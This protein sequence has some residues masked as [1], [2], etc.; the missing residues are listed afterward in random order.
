MTT[1]S[2]AWASQHAAHV[3]T[4]GVPTVAMVALALGAE[5]RSVVRRRARRTVVVSRRLTLL[6]AVCSLGA[7]AAHV[8]VAPE[9][10]HEAVLYGAFF[11]VAASAQLAWA[12]L[13]W[14]RPRRATLVAGLVGNASIVGLWVFTRTAE[15]PFGPGAGRPEGIGALDIVATSCEVVLVVV[16][17]AILASRRAPATVRP[18]GQ[19]VRP[20]ALGASYRSS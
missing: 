9:H 14:L 1:S 18:L 4:V 16:T 20:A 2:A 15:V 3:L 7:T 6:A 17:A 13:V 10:F 11:T 8:R 19:V 12:L 5:L